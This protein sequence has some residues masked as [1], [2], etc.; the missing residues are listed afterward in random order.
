MTSVSG[1]SFDFFDSE[2]QKRSASDALV[3]GVFRTNNRP[4][5]LGAFS[6]EENAKLLLLWGSGNMDP[7]LVDHSKTFGARC[8]ERLWKLEDQV[9]R[10]N[11]PLLIAG[12]SLNRIL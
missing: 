11:V 10:S 9:V 6:L 5:E 8:Y 4:T 12:H 2:F 7:A 1:C 3:H